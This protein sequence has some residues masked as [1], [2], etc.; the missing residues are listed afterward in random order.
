M[1]KIFLI[2]AGILLST[3][4]YGQETAQPSTRPAPSASD[5]DPDFHFGMKLSPALCWLGSDTKD[6]DPDGSLFRIS[7]GFIADFRFARNYAFST[8]VDV[9][10]RGGKLARETQSSSGDTTTSVVYKQDLKIQHIEIPITVRLKTNQIGLIKYYLQFGVT[11]GFNIRARYDGETT[12]QKRATN[13]NT[14]STVELE[15]EDVADDINL[16]NLSMVIGGGIEYNLSGTTNLIAGI[17]YTNGFI[18]ITND[19]AEN[20]VL[21][22]SKLNS[23]GLALTVGILF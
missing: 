1:K 13:F 7:Y 15:D 17:T 4:T 2:F 23:N 8:G 19:D 11:N 20:P 22:D 14:T 6:V 18:D 9:S 10:Y 21:K 3:L 16:Y 12:T 5:E